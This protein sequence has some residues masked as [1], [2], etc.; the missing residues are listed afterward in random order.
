MQLD[1]E[2]ILRDSF[3]GHAEHLPS[4]G[5]TND[6]AAEWARQSDATLPLLVAADRQT[7]GRGRGAKRWW[8]G[9]GALVFSLLVDA[10]TLGAERGPAPLAA[11]ATAVAVVDTVKWL[12]PEREAGIRWP[13]DVLAADRKVA[14][15]LIEAMPDRRHVIGIGL[16]TNNTVADAPA[17]LRDTV[18]TLRDLGQ[19]EFDQTDVLIDLLNRLDAEFSRLRRDPAGVAERADAVC[20][21]RGREVTFQW[22]QRVA[23]GRCRGIAADGAIQ[24]ETAA[25]VE[26]FCSGV[27]LTSP[28]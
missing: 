19:R 17:E 18:A 13:N 2:R 8:T 26:A 10:E 20:L 24:I 1:V 23:T 4:V 21:Q 27:V 9:D 7:A 3:V 16:N 22:G 14:G 25:G 28:R 12:L 6:R 15:I 5:S 11:L